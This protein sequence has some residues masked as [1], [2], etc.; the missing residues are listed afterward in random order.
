M[1]G[2]QL[3]FPSSNSQNSYLLLTAQTR[4]EKK[5]ILIEDKGSKRRNIH[6]VPKELNSYLQR[7]FVREKR[8]DFVVHVE[9]QMVNKHTKIRFVGKE[10]NNPPAIALVSIS[11]QGKSLLKR[12]KS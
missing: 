9:L 7:R 10:Q 5:G 1:L 11:N 12:Y 2:P 8:I 6:L 4:I 3:S